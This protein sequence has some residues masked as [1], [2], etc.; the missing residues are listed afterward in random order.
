MCGILGGWWQRPPAKLDDILGQ[1]VRSLHHRGPNDCGLNLDTIAD[2]RLALGHTRLSILDLSPAGHQPR[3]SGNG[4]Y[5]LSFNGE[6]YNYRELREELAQRGHTFSTDTDTEVL[7]T[8]WEAWGVAALPRLTGMFAFAVFDRE[9]SLLTLAVDP[10]AIKPL[11]WRHDPERLLFAS[12]QRTLRVLADESA[13][14]DWQSASDYL[15]HGVYDDADT[16][17]IAGA[18]RLPPGHLL[19]WRPGTGQAPSVSA[20]W[21]PPLAPSSTLSFDDAVDCVREAFLDNIRL[22]LRSDV[23]VGAA[24][25]GGIDSSAIVCGMRF[26]EPDLPIHTVG[27]VASNSPKSEARWMEYVNKHVGAN[28]HTVSPN[29]QDLS[30]DLDDLIRTQGEPF[31]STSIYAQYRVFRTAREHGL[32][33]M[34]E[35]QGADELL[36]GYQGYPA[37]RMMSLL[38]TGRFGGALDFFR[39]WKNWPG[40]DGMHLLRHTASLWMGDR[41]YHALRARIGK[42][43]SPSWLRNP[44]LDEAGIRSDY[45]RIVPG[46]APPGRRVIQQLGTEISRRGLPALLRQGDRNAMR[47]SIENRVPFL[48]R[49]FAELLLSLPENYLVSP[50]GE[51][52]HVLRIALRGIVPE[53][54]L[55]RRDKIGF[56][57]PEQNWLRDILPQVRTWIGEADRI[58][59]F[60]TPALQAD[61]E[62]IMSGKTPFSWQVWR[63]INFIRWFLI[64]DIRA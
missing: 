46:S 20:W 24:L 54:V 25:S 42:T 62:S 47:F 6:I 39:R 21:S 63:W 4:R 5:V 19:Q 55:A 40:R 49:D 35:G 12:E 41:T 17:F 37:Y 53:A 59:F 45:P 61:L 3:I 60:N 8:A 13:R 34:L 56:E 33:V 57:T 16:T 1:A 9:A 58:P 29:P 18:K 30:R 11:F 52:K 36:A 22:H 27:F 2:G 38:E 44:L 48:T 14:L 26:I 10:F 43:I 15:V 64:E 51:T 28:V 31:G 32:T 23:P 50:Q 7:L